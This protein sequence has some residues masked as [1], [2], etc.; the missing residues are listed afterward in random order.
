MSCFTGRTFEYGEISLDRFDGENLNSTV[1]FLSHC[2]YDH[3]V[4]LAAPEFSERL[5]NN[6]SYKLYCHPVTKGLLM[7]MS[8]FEHLHPFIVSLPSDEES[9]LIEVP[10]VSDG[11]DRDQ[12]QIPQHI[13]VTLIPAGHCPGSVM[14]LLSGENGT[15]LY[16]GDFRYHVGD[17]V[18]LKS[19]FTPSGLLRHSIDSVYAD[20]TF[21]IP[22][23]LTIPSRELCRD[24]I[25]QY[26]QDWLQREETSGRQIVHVFGRSNY[27]YEFLMIAM[28]KFFKT[29]LHVT[30]S[31]Y[32]RYR[33][34]PSIFSVL[35]L[36]PDTLVH[37]CKQPHNSGNG[38]Q[39]PC[40][41]P[42]M[43]A[44]NV[45]QIIPSVLYF[46]RSIKVS[47]NDMVVMEDEKSFRICYSSHSSYEEIVDFI[48]ALQPKNVYPNVKPNDS[49]SLDTLRDQMRFLECKEEN[50][51][52]QLL[53]TKK[54]VVSRRSGHQPTNSGDNSACGRI[55]FR[56][57]P[58]QFLTTRIHFPVEQINP[59]KCYTAVE[60]PPPHVVQS[61]PVESPTK[62]GGIKRTK[63]E[64][65]NNHPVAETGVTTSSP[66]HQTARHERSTFSVPD[67]LELL[68][69][70]L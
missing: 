18:K 40:L 5:S 14:F 62:F 8:W 25:I 21:F 10:K 11:S 23:A 57:R 45:L 7:G 24:L 13:A 35:T 36:D 60:S 65:K 37:F 53:S 6:L 1:Y 58:V 32:Q 54:I 63:F 16:T 26:A 2:H 29:K 22:E 46:A 52:S 30:E 41:S 50:N 70:L 69:L 19:L 27:G 44:V 34:V 42:K 64:I 12:H 66:D 68:K 3:M 55:V 33:F 43:G 39:M 61:T 9:H 51:N 49:I 38:R 17:A 15:V 47:P 56:K 20:T 28:A 31:Q 48:N 4:G 67:P 59:S